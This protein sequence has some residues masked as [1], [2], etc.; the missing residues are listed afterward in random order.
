[1]P[2]GGF[3]SEE[4]QG[5]EAQGGHQVGRAS[6]AGK[7]WCSEAQG[8]VRGKEERDKE[9]EGWRHRNHGQGAK[10]DL[11]P[12][13]VPGA[14]WKPWTP[15]W[16]LGSSLSFCHEPLCDPGPI[17]SIEIIPGDLALILE[18]DTPG[19]FGRSLYKARGELAEDI[20]GVPSSYV[21]CWA[22]LQGIAPG[23]LSILP[24]LPFAC[25]KCICWCILGCQPPS[26]LGLH[27][28]GLSF[29]YAH[30]PPKVHLLASAH[31]RLPFWCLCLRYES[32]PERAVPCPKPYNWERLSS[33][34]RS[35]GESHG[36]NPTLSKA[37]PTLD[38]PQGQGA[39]EDQGNRDKGD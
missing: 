36:V 6:R 8:R 30:E 5:L 18:M 22:D 23:C 4:R 10:G 1:M 38:W 25:L 15:V 7:A 33:G 34:L 11:C 12:H 32:Q 20:L 3:A 28:W 39:G 24:F 17:L 16:N 37:L 2:S 29:L 21:L 26:L 35:T 19:T 13:A 14:T 9:G 27:L 31:Q